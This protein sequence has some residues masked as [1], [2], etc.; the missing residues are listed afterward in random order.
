MSAVVSRKLPRIVRT[1]CLAAEEV[2]VAVA[3]L[4]NTVMVSAKP[5]KPRHHVAAVGKDIRSLVDNDVQQAA[6]NVAT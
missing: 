2:K 1:S 3:L 5:S 4:P 6:N